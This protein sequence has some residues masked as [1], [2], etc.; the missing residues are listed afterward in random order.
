MGYALILFGILFFLALGL[1]VLF[2][3]T[4]RALKREIERRKIFEDDLEKNHARFFGILDIAN[5]AVISVNAAQ[6]VVVF[7]KGAEKIF[8]YAAAEVLGQPL[9]L[10]IPKRFHE[11][12]RKHVDT[13]RQSSVVN[14]LMAERSEVFGIRKNGQEFPCEASISKFSIGGE[15]LFTAILRDITQRKLSEQL[16]HASLREKEVLLKEI[17]HRVKNN[18]QII[19]SLLNLQ[20]RYGTDDGALELLKESQNRVKTI[21]LIHEM[22]YQ[23]SDLAQIDFT[24]YIQGLT[25]NLLRSYGGPKGV[26]MRVS[27]QGIRL[28][29]DTAIPCGL[30]INELVS[31]SV[32]HAFPGARGGIVRVNLSRN[33][34][35]EFIL[36]VSD[37][38]IGF[39]SEKDIFSVDTLGLRLVRNLTEQL[40]GRIALDRQ[41]GTKF[42]IT[43]QENM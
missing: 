4:N 10:L 30:I 19:S 24:E 40:S 5:D 21:A 25:A 9:D 12:H 32:K 22:L 1:A 43:F 29:L 13:F 28:G 38:G 3:F 18:L 41:A 42:L 23:S 20:S 36:E 39:S 8:G 17:H 35:G 31:N 2:F 11:T 26:E 37:N 16:V 14:R 33:S 15:S 34:A 6:E 7:N 27:G